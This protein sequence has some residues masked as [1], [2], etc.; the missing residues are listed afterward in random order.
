MVCFPPQSP[1]S[2]KR[3]LE[4]PRK[5]ITFLVLASTAKELAMKAPSV[6]IDAV[7]GMAV[8][9]AWIRKLLTDLKV[10]KLAFMFFT[11]IVL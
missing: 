8:V 6:G 9:A 2:K 5:P 4:K 7:G 3:K 1:P 10:Q 11:V